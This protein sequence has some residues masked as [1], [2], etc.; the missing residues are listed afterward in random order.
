VTRLINGLFHPQ[1]TGILRLLFQW[2]ERAWTFS[3]PRGSW[4]KIFS[5]RNPHT[6]PYHFLEQH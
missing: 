2:R 4:Q 6:S 1:D 5:F 3:S